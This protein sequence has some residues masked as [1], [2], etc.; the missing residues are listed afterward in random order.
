[1]CVLSCKANTLPLSLPTVAPIRW[2]SRY[3]G[4]AGTGLDGASGV[5]GKKSAP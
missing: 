3:I 5:R 4:G 1:L 2:R